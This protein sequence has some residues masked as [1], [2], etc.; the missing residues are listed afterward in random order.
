MSLKTAVLW[1][2]CCATLQVSAAP[3]RDVE[4]TAAKAARSVQKKANAAP[5][6]TLDDYLLW[7]RDSGFAAYA[8]PLEAVA[9]DANS[10]S[11]SCAKAQS[12]PVN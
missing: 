5:V 8:S 12:V 9:P 10:L 3:L 4:S 7:H 2:F 11:E 1:S 6:T